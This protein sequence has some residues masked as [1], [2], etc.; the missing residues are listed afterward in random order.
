MVCIVEHPDCNAQEALCKLISAEDAIVLVGLQ[1][2][3]RGLFFTSAE[4][5]REEIKRE[6]AVRPHLNQVLYSHHVSC[7][8]C[9]IEEVVRYPLREVE[10]SPPQQVERTQYTLHTAFKQR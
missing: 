6:I 8:A 1:T 7:L 10:R 3:T 4:G 2:A 9:L 5:V